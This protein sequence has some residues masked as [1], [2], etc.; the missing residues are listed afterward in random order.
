MTQWGSLRFDSPP[1]LPP[2]TAAPILKHYDVERR[3]V[4][5]EYQL[6]APVDERGV[7]DIF[8]TVQLALSLVDDEYIW[9]CDDTEPDIHHFVWE[10][11]WY[12][13]RHFGGSLVPRDYRDNIPFHK[14][15]LPRPVHDFLHAVVAPPPVPDFSVMEAR[16]R[17]YEI[18]KELFES[19]RGAITAARRPGKIAGV[20]VSPE[21]GD[22]LLDE[23]ILM[24]IMINFN[25]YFENTKSTFEPGNDFI[26]DADIIE[27]SPEIIAT[28]L[29]KVAARNA[30]NLMPY[31]YGRRKLPRTAA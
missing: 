8:Q 21:T 1:H 16:V 30:I 20:P 2:V 4:D 13:P 19:A 26:P 10:R 15:Y 22:V 14:G 28:E 3:R 6:E 7:V 11:D 23:E 17:D 5:A 18:A 29:G 27:K 25:G 9:P 12:H 24:Q 31:I